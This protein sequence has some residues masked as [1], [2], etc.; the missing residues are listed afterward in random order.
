[1]K[2]QEDMRLGFSNDDDTVNRIAKMDMSHNH[3]PTRGHRRFYC[4]KN[5]PNPSRRNTKKR[6]KEIV[7]DPYSRSPEPELC[8]ICEEEDTT[9][10]VYGEPICR[11]CMTA[12]EWDKFTNEGEQ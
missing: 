12:D 5:S 7:L 11:K 10:L 8:V 2:P 1:V 4:L 9:Y 3:A 6:K